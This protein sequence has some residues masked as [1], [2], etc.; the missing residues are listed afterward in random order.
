MPVMDARDDA[1]PWQKRVQPSIPMPTD[2]LG[3]PIQSDTN[4]TLARD[5]REAASMDS[6]VVASPRP[7]WRCPNEVLRRLFPS[8]T[9]HSLHNFL[10]H[11]DRGPNI[12]LDD[13]RQAEEANEITHVNARAVE[14][15]FSSSSPSSEL[16]R[17]LQH[18]IV[19]ELGPVAHECLASHNSNSSLS[20]APSAPSALS[21][22]SLP[23]DHV[24]LATWINVPPCPKS[25]SM[26]ASTSAATPTM[27]RSVSTGGTPSTLVSSTYPHTN[28]SSH[29][30]RHLA[31]RGRPPLPS[32]P[33]VPI[34]PSRSSS[35][36]P[37]HAW[38]TSCA[39][40]APQTRSDG[41]RTLL[42]HTISRLMRQGPNVSILTQGYTRLNNHR[43]SSG[44][45][46]MYI[47]NAETNTIV[48]YLQT[49]PWCQLLHATSEEFM[50]WLLS[51]TMM[52]IEIENQCLVQVTGPALVKLQKAI[53]LAKQQGH[54]HNR[55]TSKMK[56]GIGGGGIATTN[57]P[58]SVPP[59]L[60]SVTELPLRRSTSLATAPHSHTH[61]HSHDRTESHASTALARA[62]SAVTSSN[63]HTHG[64]ASAT[65][66]TT[67]AAI[68]AISSSISSVPRSHTPPR[69]RRRR[70]RR[71]YVQPKFLPLTTSLPRSTM[72]YRA[73]IKSEVGLPKQ[74]QSCEIERRRRVIS[75][76]QKSL[77]STSSVEFI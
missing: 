1:N 68:A 18:T 59:L 63:K 48:T 74:R 29:P 60:S 13:W 50:H 70:R 40:R 73:P 47:H 21:N 7:V 36:A 25:T 23:F 69:R 5:S 43:Y 44:I 53:N 76:A 3:R 6:S 31:D 65:I 35:V 30:P 4:T 20:T 67:T 8:H 10:H 22:P 39:A 27:T 15:S 64:M 75:M 33:P 34:L 41:M 38:Q 52:F 45:S 28:S 66:A 51:Y 17:L 54:Q 57:A 62:V 61:S 19:V 16:S 11:A 46:D 55:M 72:F 42:L 12:R 14:S 56:G 77:F 37:L 9:I 58:T 2:R 71:C 32:P 24:S 26:S 49:Q